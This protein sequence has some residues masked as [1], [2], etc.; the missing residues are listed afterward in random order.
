[1]GTLELDCWF[2]AQMVRQERAMDCGVV[3]F[4]GLTGL[5]RP[6]AI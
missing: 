5:S 2:Q 1:M 4:G 6:G 3:M